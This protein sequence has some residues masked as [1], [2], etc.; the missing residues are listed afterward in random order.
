MGY[1]ERGW[2][3]HQDLLVVQKDELKASPGP[4]ADR[5]ADLDLS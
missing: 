2:D 3:D 1:V 4:F 5:H